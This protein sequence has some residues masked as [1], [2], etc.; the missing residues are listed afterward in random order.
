MSSAG[1]THPIRFDYGLGPDQFGDFIAARTP[2]ARGTVVFVHGGVWRAGRGWDGPD[3]VIDRLAALGWHV[4]KV[5]FRGVGAGGGWPQTGED[6]VA[7]VRFL[8]TFSAQT[9]IALGPIVLVGHSSGGQLAVRALAEVGDLVA[10]AVSADGV[11]DLR[12]AEAAGLGAGGIP[13]FL[14][15]SST[16]LPDGYRSADPL[17]NIAAESPVR[18]VHAEDDAAVPVAQSEAYLQAA[19]SAGQDAELVLTPGEHTSALD[20]G[21]A[22]WAAVLTAIEELTARR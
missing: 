13:E 14:G 21:S 8:P 20:P 3:A 4:W 2:A 17:R 15:G 10:G 6:V 22:A 1:T 12:A 11:L 5:Q 9:G 7:A 16:D 18:L 19:R